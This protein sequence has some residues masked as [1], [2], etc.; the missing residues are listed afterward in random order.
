MVRPHTSPPLA[1][2]KRELSLGQF[3]YPLTRFRAWL[4]WRSLAGGRC[5]DCFRASPLLDRHW[6]IE[7]LG[8]DRA[9]RARKIAGRMLV[10]RTLGSKI[11]LSGR[12]TR[13]DLELLERTATAYELAAIEGLQALL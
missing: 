9:A 11:A 3:I 10:R 7:A 8:V 12:S 13:P 1:Q 4:R 6:A 5:D 2:P